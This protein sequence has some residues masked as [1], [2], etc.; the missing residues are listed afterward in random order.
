MATSGACCSGNGE[1]AAVDEYVIDSAEDGPKVWNAE[2]EQEVFSVGKIAE[3]GLI[4]DAGRVSVGKEVVSCG[5]GVLL[6]MDHC[7]GERAEK[8]CVGD[9]FSPDVAVPVKALQPRLD[10]RSSGFN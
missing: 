6:E 9:R 5:G 8:A 1:L 7:D 2:E 3:V 4:E 10:K